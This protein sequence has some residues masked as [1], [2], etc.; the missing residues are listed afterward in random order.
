MMKATCGA[1]APVAM[2]RSIGAGKMSDYPLGEPKSL[3]PCRTMTGTGAR[4]N[5]RETF[6]PVREISFAGVIFGMK[7]RPTG[8]GRVF[9]TRKKR[10]NLCSKS[11]EKFWEVMI[12]G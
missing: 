9:D 7:L 8:D 5:F 10:R 4:V 11:F 3:Q 1:C 2:R 12:W 6:R